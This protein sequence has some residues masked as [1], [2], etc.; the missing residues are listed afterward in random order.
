M[1]GKKCYRCGAPLQKSDYITV[2]VSSKSERSCVILCYSCGDKVESFI[3]NEKQEAEST[4]DE[5][6]ISGEKEEI[7]PIPNLQPYI[8]YTPYWSIIHPCYPGYYTNDKDWYHWPD[9]SK[10]II[11]CQEI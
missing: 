10:T 8:V 1:L 5:T 7:T 9:S 3:K 2:D 6:L 11:T 4:K